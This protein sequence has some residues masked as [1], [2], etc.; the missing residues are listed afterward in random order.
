MEVK[1]NVNSIELEKLKAIAEIIRKNS[2][3]GKFTKYA[4]LI[5]ETLEVTEENI[6]QTIE[7]LKASEEYNDIIELKGKRLKY[8]Y[9]QKQM[10][11]NYAK[12]MFRIEE[13][14]L[15][16]LVVETVRYESETYPRP[17][18]AHAFSD[19]PFYF[20]EDALN[21]VFNQIKENAAYD[22]IQQTKASNGEVYLY[23]AKYLTEDYAR[24]LAEWIEIKQFENP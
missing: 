1:E 23:S 7:S 13:N 20:T 14:D 10:T 8:L 4:D 6:N 19:S 2:A 9:S 16:K 5:S 22:D 24:V 11:E 21:D 12:M 3:D 17:T 18:A 15:L